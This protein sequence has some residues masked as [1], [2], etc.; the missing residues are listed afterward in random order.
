MNNPRL[1]FGMTL[2]GDT[3]FAI[4]GA[5]AYRQ[6]RFDTGKETGF[7]ME[8]IKIS[9]FGAHWHYKKNIPVYMDNHCT[10]ALSDTEI[11]AIGGWQ[12]SLDKTEKGVSPMNN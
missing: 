5:P 3:I 8:S 12:I 7:T 9:S 11:I 4:G 2:V 10:V 6:G 1:T